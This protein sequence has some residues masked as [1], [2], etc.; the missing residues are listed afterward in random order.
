MHPK[1]QL[2]AVAACALIFFCYGSGFLPFVGPD[3]PRYSQVARQMLESGDF[4]SP[5]LGDF[6]WFEKPVLLYW[7]IALCYF[8]F[9][10]NEFAARFPSA[11]AAL[12]SVLFVYRTVARAAGSTRGLAAAI[13]LSVSAFFFGFSH[14]ATFDMLLTFCITAALCCL[15]MFEIER[16]NTRFL[17]AFYVFLGLGLLAKGFVALILTGLTVAS[18]ITISGAWRNLARFRPFTGLLITGAISLIWFAPVSLVSGIGFWDDFFYKHQFVRYT[19]SYYHRSGGVFFYLPV[20]LL[21]TYPWS[22][23]PFLG[24]DRNP[25]PERRTLLRIAVCW[26]FTTVLF[27]TFSRSKLPGYILPAAPAYSMLAGIALVDFIETKTSRMRFAVLFGMLNLILIA[28]VLWGGRKFAAPAEAAILMACAIAAFSFAG[29]LFACRN[30][31][32]L[33]V[34]SFALILFSGAAIAIHILPE[35]MNW[36]ESRMLSLAVQ[37]KLTGTRKLLLYHVY[38]FSPVFYTNARVELTPEG[39]PVPV[40]DY[41]QLHRYVRAKGEAFVL[42]ANEE[43]VWM[44]TADFW[45]V[46]DVISGKENSIVHL[47]AK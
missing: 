29:I 20:L 40:S 47:R 22:V 39:T 32:K 5:H 35:K 4:I 12:L 42:V 16:K 46:M 38:D 26:F 34:V 28:A 11:I 21:G 3:E 33:S 9:G 37:P 23:A 44:R 13:C 17:Y 31:W 45:Q 18:T 14:A 19:S 24:Y 15:A 7:L 1:N 36:F 6:P 43:L 25:S 8:V 27:F 10:I 30:K 41:R 2:V